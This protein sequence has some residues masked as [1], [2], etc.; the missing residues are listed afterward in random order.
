MADERDSFA[1]IREYVASRQTNAADGGESTP[2]GIVPQPIDTAVSDEKVSDQTPP[3]R[4]RR[5][6][7]PALR[8][9][10]G[11]LKAAE[12][13]EIP[14][15]SDLPTPGGIALMLGITLF[16]L[17]ALTPT[18]QGSS[19]LGLMWAALLGRASYAGAGSGTG[20]AGANGG[21]AG[22]GGVGPELGPPMGGYEMIP[23]WP[24]GIGP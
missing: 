20:G 24:G 8:V 18:S 15:L 9:I 16:I 3:A 23:A 5:T 17:F 1:V 10:E 21:V 14:S 12:Q 4:R 2:E 11:G 6:R 7:R 22:S 13:A 19:R